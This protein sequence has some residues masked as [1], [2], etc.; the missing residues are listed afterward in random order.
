MEITGEYRIPA[1]RGTVWEALNDPEVLRHC[2]P[3]CESLEKV[4]DTEFAAKVNAKVGPVKS[5]FSGKVELS[6]IDAP[7]SYRISGQG[8]GGVAGFAKGAADVSLAEEGEE[9]VLSYTAEAQVG[10]KLAQLGSR[11]IAGTARKMADE[12]FSNFATRLGAPADAVE[13]EMK[14][15]EAPG[16]TAAD[17]D[18]TAPRS[19]AP[20]S[21]ET[22]AEEA[23]DESESTPER[24]ALPPGVWIAGLV[25]VVAG[26]LAIVAR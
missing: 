4:S 8:Q 20:A 14:V 5:K 22:P 18:Q 11:L 2:I 10:G 9:T 21:D 1:P 7:K 17:E 3:G 24:K 6:D 26:V 13:G 16:G 19:A 12:F 23:R 15:E 25:A